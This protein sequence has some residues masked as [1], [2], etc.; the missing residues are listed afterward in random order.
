MST[1]S[2]L[3]HVT[4][5][6]DDHDEALDFYTG[7]LGFE[8]RADD[9][10]GD[11]D[12]WVTIAPADTDGPE[13]ALVEADTDAK[14]ERVGSQ[15]GDHVLFVLTT[16]DCHGTYERLTA[17]GVTFHG[18]PESVP[19]GVEVTFEDCYGNVLDLLEP[20]MPNR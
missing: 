14:R 11:G 5:L 13:L 6:V 7:T 1:I 12:R 16:D 19:W 15:A 9:E 4:L 2:G 8:T 10:M 20:G 3:S 17:A 18:E